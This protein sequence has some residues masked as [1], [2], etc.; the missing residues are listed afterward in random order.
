MAE[1][2]YFAYVFAA[3][4][5][6]ILGLTLLSLRSRQNLMKREKSG[7]AIEFLSHIKRRY[8][9]VGLIVGFLFFVGSFLDDFYG[10]V[11]QVMPWSGI[12]VIMLS[13]TFSLT[14]MAID[15]GIFRGLRKIKYFPVNEYW[16]SMLDGM[17]YILTGLF[18]ISVVL[19][20]N[21]ISVLNCC[22]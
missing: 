10:F 4:S 1:S 2:S 14:F 7:Q 19:G 22:V 9:I 5:L 15:W 6:L 18:I 13:L 21:P 12:L 20:M 17:T 11:N 16:K 8:Q 3:E